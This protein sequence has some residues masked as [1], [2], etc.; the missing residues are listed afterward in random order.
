MMRYLFVL[1]CFAAL[2]AAPAFAVLERERSQKY[3]EEALEFL[4]KDSVPEA[5]IQ[6]RNALQQDPNNLSARIEM[7][8]ALLMQ[9]QPRA[10]IKELEAAQAMGA[11]ENLLL[12]PL[13]QA[14]LEVAEPE[15][16]LSGF[17]A[18]GHKPQV[19][20]ELLL[21]QAEAYLAMSDPKRAEEAYLS[22]GTLLPVD[23]RPILGRSRIQMARGKSAESMQLIEEALRLAPDSFDVWMF[24]G[25]AHRDHHQYPDAIKA[26]ERA[27]QINPSSGRAL[28]ARAAM[29]IDLGEMDKAKADLET[30]KELDSNLL[31][32]VY[33]RTL[34]LFR[35]GHIDEARQLLRESAE[36]IQLIKEDF[37]AKLPETMLMLGVVAYFEGNYSEAITL[38]KN[39]LAKVPGNSGA[40]RY[41]AASYVELEEGGNAIALIRPNANAEMPRDPTLLSLLAESYR[42][43]G[44]HAAAEK[45]YETALQLAPNAAGLGVR[46]AVAR[47]DAGRAAAAV[48][49]LEDLTK[50]FPDLSE[51]WCQL[52]RVYVKT[53]NLKRATEIAE[54]LSERFK[55]QAEVENVV[56]ATYMAG[57][58]LEKARLHLTHAQSLD[59]TLIMPQ[60]NLARLLRM[61]GDEASAEAQYRSTLER[62]P[63]QTTA[64][65]ELTEMLLE[66]GEVAEAS[67]RVKQV[68][69]K[70]PN[71][72]AAHELKIKLTFAANRDKEDIRNT[73]YDLLKAFP[74]SPQAQLLGGRAYRA[75]GQTADARVRFRRAVELAEFD[76]ETLYAA[77]NQQ[78]AIADFTGALWTLTKAE[79]ASPEHMGVGVLKAAVLV[80]LKEFVKADEVIKQLLDK[81]GKTAEIMTVRGDMLMGQQQ[82]PQAVEAYQQAYQVTPNQTT[83]QTLFRAQVAANQ[84]ADANRLMQEWLAKHSTDLSSMHLFAQMLMRE[85]RW[86]EARKAYEALQ[87]AGTEDIV[88]LNNL[89]VCYQHLKDPR[90]LPTAEAAFKK[91]PKD[92]SVADTY[93]W[94][95]LEAGE[96]DEALALLREAFARASTSPAIRYHIGL[97]L[98]RLGREAEAKDEVQAAVSSSEGFSSRDEA[99]S[100]LEQLKQKIR[101]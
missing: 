15:H 41:L 1:I 50:H 16:V 60:I 81:H 29:W 61:Q 88:M 87:A 20:G 12:N 100:L 18:H 44:N 17:V 33:L 68:L 52:A 75:L 86:D 45:A 69:D 66:H 40:V 79:Q 26:F 53:G 76:A 47:L 55:D 59:A 65:L 31:E 28:S 24:K 58:E 90:A 71:L 92:P 37:R 6:L 22:A 34:I 21:Q 11:D 63:Q 39:Y 4:R 23:P 96:V 89:A 101:K 56:G 14:Y 35:D 3:Y 38:L 9:N 97:A 62:F 30:A 95:L 80:E 77:A 78:Y 32:T 54:L 43:V 84:I 8:R 57:G 10:A 94:I 93:G 48:S 25:L 36:Q 67:D 82:A 73:V 91:A 7:G 13:A 46:L 5:V 51:A 19:D 42:M 2:Y 70:Q 64:M 27:L 72:F 83:L 98:A 74:N 49:E 99:T 85:K